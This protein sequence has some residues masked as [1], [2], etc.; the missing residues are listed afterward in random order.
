MPDD[1]LEKIRNII[2]QKD[3]LIS[4]FKMEISDFAP[5][6]AEVR[7]KVEAHHVN[8][9]GVCHGGVM[10]SLADVSF[11][12]ACNSH[13]TL[14]LA[15]DMSITY[16]KPVPPGEIITARCTERHRGRSTAT[17]I[18]EVV[19][20]DNNLVALLKATAFRK[21]TLLYEEGDEEKSF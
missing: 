6:R 10:F 18:I 12:L 4:L 17:Y 1:L 19:N 15:L 14:A 3:M 20:S 9:A 7:M 13:G 21:N 16:V 2:N 8:A 11:A 5:G